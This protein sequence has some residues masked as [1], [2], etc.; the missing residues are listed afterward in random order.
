MIS[1]LS[2]G[3]IFSQPL[4]YEGYNGNDGEYLEEVQTGIN[5]DEDYWDVKEPDFL[6]FS[7]DYTFSF[8]D[9][10]TSGIAAYRTNK[11][12]SEIRYLID[13]VDSYTGPLTPYVIN[14]GDF[15]GIGKGGETI[16]LSVFIR[17]ENG[18]RHLICLSRDH[19]LTAGSTTN[20]ALSAGFLDGDKLGLYTNDDNWPWKLDLD[21]QEDYVQYPLALTSDHTIFLVLK[22]EFAPTGGG[23]GGT[24]TMWVDPTIGGNKPDA[25]DV[26]ISRTTTHNFVFKSVWFNGDG[27]VDEIRLGKSFSDVTPVPSPTLDA[28]KSPE[29]VWDI[30]GEQ[31][32]TLTGISDGVDSDE[33]ISILATSSNTAVVDDP[34][35]DYSSPNN[36]ATLKYNPLMD[37]EAWIKVTVSASNVPGVKVDSFRV[38]VKNSGINHAPVIE[39]VADIML[40]NRAGGQSVELSGIDDGDLF[41]EQNVTINAVSKNLLVVSD[42]TVDYT[43]G[44]NLASL[45]FTP[46]GTAGKAEI[47]VTLT[48]DAT[49]TP[50][51]GDNETTIS[52]T[53]TIIESYDAFGWSE[54]FD[55]EN[56]DG[57]WANEYSLEESDGVLKV[58]GQKKTK[59]VPFGTSLGRTIDMTQNPYMSI[60]IKTGVLEYPFTI[61]SYIKDANDE[62]YT[63]KK[64]VGPSENYTNLSLDYSEAGSDVDMTKI[65]D[66]FFAINGNNLNWPGIVWL[67]E[68]H[69]GYYAKKMCNIA[70][71]AN[72]SYYINSGAKKIRITDIEYADGLSLTGGDDLIE[73][74]KFSDDIANGYSVLSFNIIEGATGNDKISITAQGVP[75]Y[76]D[77]TVTFNLSVSDNKVP[78]LNPIDDLNIKTGLQTQIELTGINDGDSNVEQELS[79]TAE[80]NNPDAT[81]NFSIDYQQSRTK[82]DMVFSPAT[83][84]ENIQVTVTVDD[85]HSSDNIISR[86]FTINIYD[87]L[88]N[89]PT[90][91]NVPNQ[92]AI[93]AYGK[94]MVTLKGLSDGDNGPQ[95]LT[96]AATSSDQT[97]ISE[98]NLEFAYTPGQ[99]QAF[100]YYTPSAV[101]NT[102]IEVT[103]TD[104]GGNDAN[105]GN[106]STSITFNI[107]VLEETQTGYVYQMENVSQDMDNGL[108]KPHN[109]YKGLS[110]E[111]FDG[112]SNVMKVEYNNKSNW[113]GIWSNLPIE[114]NLKDHPYISCDIY[115]VSQDIYFHIYFYDF[116]DSRNSNGAHAQRIK[117]SKGE[118]TH[119]EIDVSQEGYLLD[120]EGNPIRADRITDILINMHEKDFPFPFTKI[121]GT[122]Y[123]KNLRIGDKAIFGQQEAFCTIDEVQSQS[124][125]YNEGAAPVEIT[126]TGI[127]DGQGG[128]AQASLSVNSS[129]EDVASPTL[130]SVNTDGTATLSYTPGSYGISD[131][132]ITV[133]APGAKSVS[134]SFTV[135]VMSD[136]SDNV[137]KIDINLDE[138]H[139]LFRGIGTMLPPGKYMEM[140]GKD[141]RATACRIGI[142]G[143]AY[144][145]PFEPVN[146]NE[147]PYVLDLSKFNRNITDWDNVRYLMESGVETFIMTVWSPEAWMKDNYSVDMAGPGVGTDN[148]KTD[149]KLSYHYYDE[150]AEYLVAYCKMFL[151]ETG[152]ELTAI[153]MQNEPAF[154]EPYGSAILDPVH[155]AQLVEIVGDR[156]KE[157]GLST[158]FMVPEQVLSQNANS[159]D[160][161]IDAIQQNPK[162]DE[163]C[164][165]IAT[166]GYA[167][168]G[169]GDINPDFSTWS[170]LYGHCQKGKNPKE[171]WMTETSAAAD[172]WRQGLQKAGAIYGLLGPGNGSL[173]TSFNATGQL[174]DNFGKPTFSYK[175][176]KH[177]TKF[178]RPGAV[179]VSASSPTD[180]IFALSFQNEQEDGGGL[181]TVLINH[182]DLPMTV[183]LEVMGSAAP[184]AYDVYTTEGL[185]DKMILKQQAIQ[186][187]GVIILPAM[188]I[189]TVNGYQDQDKNT[190]TVTNGNGSGE[191]V[192][193]SP[194]TVSAGE[195]PA[196]Q[197]FY[198]WTGDILNIEDK[199]AETTT[200]TMP[201]KSIS[202]TAEYVELPKYVLTV[203]N[204]DGGGGFFPGEEISI[205]AGDSSEL[206]LE[207]KEW[208]GDIAY[209]DNPENS[210]ATVTMPGK[211]ITMK[212]SYQYIKFDVKIVLKDDHSNPVSDIAAIINDVTYTTNA[213]GQIF[214]ELDPW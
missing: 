156:F 128:T 15:K 76:A 110:Y 214:L 82:A 98:E 114:L 182:S 60:K 143:S 205:T 92:D 192:A 187:G 69:L 210:Q 107:E 194:V 211:N 65:A 14:S 183:S 83:P 163:Y 198:Q 22:I 96:L 19:K 184:I 26:S 71:P 159:M 6:Q 127:S 181:A 103:V 148:D 27:Y 47:E 176:Y 18:F 5:W 36:T 32:Y 118:W 172:T 94:Q 89:P 40:E 24:V 155:F 177:F 131:I 63:I 54:Y 12:S 9:L 153:G 150:F 164:D 133:K 119:C 64:R 197:K 3:L 169:I 190:L 206:D 207:F 73:N 91:D 195:A 180:K 50:D 56:I 188:S 78:E 146:D 136:N 70:A 17:R 59:W 209:L 121:S 38:E 16:W 179:R 160:D 191:Y 208:L 55:N 162:A 4:V 149:N 75:G 201:N 77:N 202:I 44:E 51:G 101:G 61:T 165:F 212:A 105:N 170:D 200:L 49:G 167:D 52:F 37:G 124:H 7:D 109:S 29:A 140:Y 111:S 72:K 10:L 20:A 120:K 139:Q 174:F 152:K 158:G 66:V 161:Y 97:V 112:F 123:I 141:L 196:N 138:T 31:L 90:I 102:T 48:D 178:I 129:L 21:A 43:A 171:L 28:L 86:T 203:V 113:D 2:N 126:L 62:N 23:D 213:D 80:S 132:E 81:G 1:L 95:E 116:L 13:D 175:T 134:T 204:G 154:H 41:H 125:F 85:G 151:E 142:N 35:V 168:D 30:D 166:H 25:G 58:T 8:G 130:S 137:H 173:W 135:A 117:A 93:L 68:L 99:P 39:P 106:A 115:P 87:D 108:W 67:E 11:F 189:T 100:L 199:Y 45:N 46:T 53:V 74:V 84:G 57:W 185:N 34:V 33:N 145:N 104:N 79:I 122:V 186:P 157:E 42:V 147:D 144:K 193:N 88:N